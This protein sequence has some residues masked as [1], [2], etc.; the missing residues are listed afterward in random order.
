M[1]GQLGPRPCVVISG[2]VE[3]DPSLAQQFLNIQLSSPLTTSPFTRGLAFTSCP[4]HKVVVVGGFQMVSNLRLV[5][6][7]VRQ[8]F[9]IYDGTI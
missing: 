5:S 7:S 3:L 4:C 1:F 6:I 8:L 2:D 9:W